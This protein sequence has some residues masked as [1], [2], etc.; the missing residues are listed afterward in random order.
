[1]RTGFGDGHGD[2]AVGGPGPAR[3]VTGHPPHPRQPGHRGHRGVLGQ[4]RR[5]RTVH[6]AHR[7]AQGS[8]GAGG[9]EP[10]RGG[11]TALARRHQPRVGGGA[12]EPTRPHPRRQREKHVP[13]TATPTVAA[14]RHARP[15]TTVRRCRR[16][17]AERV[18]GLRHAG[19][20]HRP[21]PRSGGS[22]DRG[23]RQRPR[24]RAADRTGPEPRG[25]G[26]QQD[27]G[28]VRTRRGGPVVGPTVRGGYR[29]VPPRL[30]GGH[31]SR[32]GGRPGEP[33]GRAR[34]QGGRGDGGGTARTLRRPRRADVPFGRKDVRD[35]VRR[36]RGAPRARTQ[37]A[38]QT[39]RTRPPANVAQAGAL[40]GG[41][42]TGL[43]AWGGPAEGHARL[44][45]HGGHRRLGRPGRAGKRTRTVLRRPGRA[46]VTEAGS[47]AVLRP[48]HTRESGG[49]HPVPSTGGRRCMTS[50]RPPC[51]TRRSWAWPAR[52]PRTCATGSANASSHWNRRSPRPTGD[53]TPRPNRK[54]PCRSGRSV[55][56]AWPATTWTDC[57]GW[58]RAN[59][60][61]RS[62][63]PE[64]T[65]STTTSTAFA[66]PTG[67]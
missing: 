42:R 29:G 13:R 52:R 32:R 51:V 58:S 14:V 49:H 6:V 64:V 15:A 33:P 57:R 62:T 41:T 35:A 5:V 1:R 3:S 22:V 16:A 27:G 60:P 10:G 61:P 8:Q 39:Q 21:T 9:G 19:T 20:G 67:T 50:P 48:R 47:G 36:G 26:Q 31:L 53:S 30:R 55:G 28:L 18:D 17:P 44:Q 45:R 25:P 7:D 11:R 56:G 40:E 34:A 38:R 65:R 66:P 2:G 37:G 59:N 54:P 12:R 43:V 4:T 46:L 63:R 24:H 23:R